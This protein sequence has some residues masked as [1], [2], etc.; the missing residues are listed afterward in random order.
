VGAGSPY[1]G[2]HNTDI[3]ERIRTKDILVLGFFF[4]RVFLTSTLQNITR[5]FNN[6][7]EAT[8]TIVNG[9]YHKDTKG[10]NNKLLQDLNLPCNKPITVSQVAL[11]AWIISGVTFQTLAP[12]SVMLSITVNMG[13]PF[14]SSS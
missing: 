5:R 9:L 6:C 8:N 2:R 1:N 3:L 11:S 13:Q 14:L 4:P 7:Q 12:A 10:G